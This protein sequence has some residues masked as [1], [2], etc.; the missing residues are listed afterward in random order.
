MPSGL[1]SIF[2]DTCTWLL[3]RERLLWLHL[4]GSDRKLIVEKTWQP[5]FC[6]VLIFIPLGLVEITQATTS[7]HCVSR[8]LGVV[9][10]LSIVTVLYGD[11]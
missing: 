9:A 7:I 10:S 1:R 2:G 8:C 11:S 6:V 5:G 4:M 3:V